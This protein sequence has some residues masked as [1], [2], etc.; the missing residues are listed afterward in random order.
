[1]RVATILILACLVMAHAGAASA[2]GEQLVVSPYP[3]PTAWKRITDKPS[4]RGWMHEQIPANQTV[5]HFTDILTDQAFRQLAG[6]DPAQFLRLIFASVVKACDGVKVD[7]PVTRQ[8]GGYVVAYAQVYCGQQR[9]QDFGVHIFY[10]AI[11]GAAALY[12]VSREFHVPAAP[13]GGH[14]AFPKGEAARAEA[15]VKA[16]AAANDY[17]EGG[18]YVCGGRSSDTRCAR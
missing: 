4:P 2:A 17:L 1:M 3:G 9:G 11:S 15:L 18:V 10:K 13:D 8:E 7:G 14:L 12:S 5:S 6:R 16:E